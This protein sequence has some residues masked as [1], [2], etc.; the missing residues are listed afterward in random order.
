MRAHRTT[1]GRRLSCS[2]PALANSALRCPTR[3]GGDAGHAHVVAAGARR[4]AA[5]ARDL[6]Q[7]A[8]ARWSPTASRSMICSLGRSRTARSVLEEADDRRLPGCVPAAGAA[9]RRRPTTGAFSCSAGSCAGSAAKWRSSTLSVD[10]EPP[11]KPRQERDWLTREEFRRLLD[12]A[13]Q[14][15]RNL[16]GLAER[17]RLALLALVTT[18]LRR[19]ELCAL[20]W[21]DL[22]LDGRKRSLLV[23]RGKGGK[24]R[25]QPVPAGLARE[26][27]EVRESRRPEANRPGLLRARRRTPAGDD[28]R[29]HHP[30]RR[31]HEPGSR[32]T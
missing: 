6:A 7:R 29:R 1:T 3:P 31:L 9:R 21:R 19:S 28:P 10:L 24:P 27:R 18:G 14:P 25:R 16:P 17:D 13:G 20:E 4:L 32:S 23:R 2:P 5:A 30:P 15:E 8:R 22:E 26:L 11:P 12:A